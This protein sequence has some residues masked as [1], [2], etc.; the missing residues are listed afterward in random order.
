MK[1]RSHTML[2]SFKL[3]LMLGLS[4]IISIG[5]QNLFIIQQAI[6]NEYTYCSALICFV[7]DLILIVLGAAGISAVFI[8]VPALKTTILILGILFLSWHG[9]QALQ[10]GL[11]GNTVND[12]ITRLKSATERTTLSKVILLGLS[13]SLLNP[14]AILDTIVIIGGSANH[15][16]HTEKY[17]FI[18]GTITASFVWFFSLASASRYLA[19]NTVTPTIWRTLDFISS[20]IM[21]SLA[22]AFLKQ[23]N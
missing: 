5:A 15:Y 1:I 9:C 23:F 6:R 16:T 4:I 19:K 11:R 20:A 12:D 3:G 13:F 14:A 22:I 10:R 18:A 21:L 7:C 8:E 17:L 2:L